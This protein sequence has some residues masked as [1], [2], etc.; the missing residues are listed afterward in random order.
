MICKIH[1]TSRAEQTRPD[2]QQQQQT[3]DVNI[4]EEEREENLFS[5]FVFIGSLIYQFQNKTETETTYIIWAWWVDG[6]IYSTYF[7]VEFKILSTVVHS[8]HIQALSNLALAHSEWK[9]RMHLEHDTLT[10]CSWHFQQK[11]SEPGW[12]QQEKRTHNKIFSI[13]RYR[14]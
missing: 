14:R 12:K 11:L 8:E 7:F 2:Q 5:L 6:C 4:F 3:M 9:L 1:C 10:L 13:N